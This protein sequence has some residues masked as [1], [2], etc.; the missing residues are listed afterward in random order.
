MKTKEFNLSEKKIAIENSSSYF[1]N[2][3]D[4]KEFIKELKGGFPKFI[5]ENLVM[6]A[7]QKIILF[8][9]ICKEIDKLAGKYL[10]EN[11]K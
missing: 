3:R 6:D 1:F 10:G 8:G 11:K 7:S 2:E 5:E 4:V 9:K